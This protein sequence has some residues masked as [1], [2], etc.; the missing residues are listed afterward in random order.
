MHAEHSAHGAIAGSCHTSEQ[1]AET[2]SLSSA[3]DGRL[4]RAALL[5][6]AGGTALAMLTASA[7]EPI[8]AHAA[9][10]AIDP[11]ALSGAPPAGYVCL[12]VL[13]GGRPD[14]ITRNL[15][16]MPNLRSL[17]TRSR[18]YNRAWV[19]DLMSITPPGHAVIGTGSFPKND[20]GIVNWDWGIHSTGKISPTTQALENYQNGWVFNLIK[21]S[22]TPTLAGVIRKKYPEDPV[23]AGSGAHFHA[24]GPLGG[25]DASWIF[26]YTRIS[27]YWAPYTLGTHAVPARLLHDP[28]LRV[29]LPS[30]NNSTV[31]L[32]Y[33]PVPLGQQ[34]SLVMDFAIKALQQHRPRAMLL[35]LPEVDAVGH[36]SK[37]WYAEAAIV[38]RRFDTSL[39]RL[40]DAYKSAGIYDRTLFVIT[41][42]H[43]MIQSKDRVL[44]RVSVVDQIKSTLGESS[45]ILTNGGGSA[46]PTMTSIWLKDPANNARMAKAI[47]DKRYDNVSAIFYMNRSGGGN[48]YELAGVENGSAD[49]VKT[50]RYMLSTAAGPTGPDIAILLRENARNSGMPEMPGRHGGADWGSQHITLIMSGPGVKIGSSNAPARLVDI[51]PTIERFM[52][53]APEARDGI[54]LADAFQ[55]PH[56]S[57]VTVQA[58]QDTKTNVY[59][60]ALAARARHDIVLARQ[61]LLPNTIPADEQPP[62]H[63]MRRLAVTAAGVGVL[64]GTGAGLAKAV[65]AVRRQASRLEWED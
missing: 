25:P 26:S 1:T 41:A 54:V 2:A 21:E 51:A 46:G 60:N 14:Y 33:D 24:A 7:L 57:D 36:W 9:A 35:N 63:W 37:R 56:P 40:I 50:Y 38:Y 58:Q 3:L 4:S 42:D 12:I 62:I 65:A 23:I 27:G 17:L 20:G 48:R 61:G 55:R 19:G 8:A 49:L 28:S 44:D 39:G 10:P 47:F 45:I 22:G 6:I 53:M 29:S 32:T 52:G 43:G 5:K 13:D 30:S 15:P 31:P 11:E 16:A 64:G 34:D 18:V 59:V